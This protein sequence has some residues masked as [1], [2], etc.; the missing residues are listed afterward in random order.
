MNRPLL[1][2]VL[3]FALSTGCGE[4]ACRPG[5][6]SPP[7]ISVLS[8]SVID[9]NIFANMMPIVPPDPIACTLTVRIENTSTKDTYTG[10]GVPSASVYSAANEPVGRF[11]FYSDWD[12][13][14]GPC[15]ID[16]FTIVKIQEQQPVIDNPCGLGL[17]LDL[18]IE[19]ESYGEAVVR[20]PNYV[21]ACAF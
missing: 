4:D 16:T 8:A 11:R 13:E 14:L 21:C 3:V 19:T 17:Y 5:G 10:I 2:A 6:G 1:T 20:T 7:P 9:G 12:G 15:G 18:L